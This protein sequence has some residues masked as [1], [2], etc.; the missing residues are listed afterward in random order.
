GGPHSAPEPDPFD[1]VRGQ[2]FIAG[3]VIQHGSE[4]PCK[5]HR[6]ANARVHPL[7]ANRTMD[8]RRIP[9]EERTAHAKPRGD[10]VMDA[11]VENQFTDAIASFSFPMAR[12]SM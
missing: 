5:V 9:E 4:L 8:M 12:S 11:Y 7:S 2:Q 3:A 1:F 6:V 10:A